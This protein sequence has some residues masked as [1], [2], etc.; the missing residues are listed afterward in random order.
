MVEGGLVVAAAAH[1]D[2]AR[3]CYETAHRVTP[4]DAARACWQPRVRQRCSKA[5]SRCEMPLWLAA[6][7]RTDRCYQSA[8]RETPHYCVRA[9]LK[10][11]AGFYSGAE[12]C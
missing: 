8:P 11:D 6:A 7:A 5:E 10:N 3:D 9:G 2:R 12:T 4:Y 1:D